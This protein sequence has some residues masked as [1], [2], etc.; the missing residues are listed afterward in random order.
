MQR[1]VEGGKVFLAGLHLFK[2]CFPIVQI[3]KLMCY[4]Y[5]FIFFSVQFIFSDFSGV[6]PSCIIGLRTFPPSLTSSPRVINKNKTV[7]DTEICTISYRL[8]T[9]L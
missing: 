7:Y 1:E 8:V 5:L 6:W 3:M 2:S 4:D 9:F